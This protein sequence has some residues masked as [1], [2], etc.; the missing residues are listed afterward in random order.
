M[1]YYKQEYNPSNKETLAF[2]DKHTPVLFSKVSPKKAEEIVH[3]YN[4]SFHTVKERNIFTQLV[5]E[6][7]QRPEAITSDGLPE[8]VGELVDFITHFGS[9]TTLPTGIKVSSVKNSKGET[10]P[11]GSTEQSES[12]KGKEEGGELLSTLSKFITGY[13]IRILE[14]IGGG[15]LILFGLWVV[16]KRELPKAVPVPV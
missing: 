6:G 12:E 8:S 5:E 2:L 15:A 4:S 16:A 10:V 11:T 7:R 14:V 3:Q 9:S 1:A 13:G